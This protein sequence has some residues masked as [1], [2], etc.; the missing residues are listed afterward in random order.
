MLP[1]AACIVCSRR[2]PAVL[3]TAALVPCALRCQYAAQAVMF[4]A[5]VLVSEVCSPS[6][7]L[8]TDAE[9]QTL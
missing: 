6:R 2:L 5:G 1:C 8:A 7:A 4:A 9:D 3:P